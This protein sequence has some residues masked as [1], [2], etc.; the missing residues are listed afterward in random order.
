[1]LASLGEPKL[2]GRRPG[3]LVGAEIDELPAVGLPLEDELAQLVGRRLARV[4]RPSLRITIIA[5]S[6]R[7]DAVETV[8]MVRATASLS[9]V[10]PRGSYWLDPSGPT[11]CSGRSLNL[12]RTGGS[13]P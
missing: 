8:R 6:P 4:S 11:S 12:T 7:S 2:V 9:G 5:R 3:V 10:I 13:P 1:M